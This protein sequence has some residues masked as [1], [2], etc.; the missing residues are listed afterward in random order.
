[1][2][3]DY[4]RESMF[5]GTQHFTKSTTDYVSITNHSTT[6]GTGDFTIELVSI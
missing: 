2:D 1:M 5:A 6:L 4:S 3:G